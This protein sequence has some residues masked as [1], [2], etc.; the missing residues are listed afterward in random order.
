MSTPDLTEQLRL[1]LH[2]CAKNDRSGVEVFSQN[3]AGAVAAGCALP[4]LPQA[5][6][7]FEE[8]FFEDL[9]ANLSQLEGETVFDTLTRHQQELLDLVRAAQ[10]VLR[11]HGTPS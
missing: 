6:G 10:D 5:L 8:S 11:E 7:E 1:L 9:S 2:A 3:L 4:D